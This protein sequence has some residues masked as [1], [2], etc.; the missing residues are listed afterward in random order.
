M[1]KNY[2]I[3]VYECIC[4]SVS[5]SATC[6]LYKNSTCEARI[7][8]LINTSPI[9]YCFQIQGPTYRAGVILKAQNKIEVVQL[10]VTLGFS[11]LIT[12]I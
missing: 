5:L 6:G 4:P 12:N 7:I 8:N 2:S 11:D 10:Y 9:T 1:T 3:M